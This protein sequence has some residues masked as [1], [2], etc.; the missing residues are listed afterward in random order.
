MIMNQHMFVKWCIWFVSAIMASIMCHHRRSLQI[1][2]AAAAAAATVPA[3]AIYNPAALRMTAAA[4]KNGGNQHQDKKKW[5]QM[6]LLH[7]IIDAQT[8][9]Y[10]H[11]NNS[12][13]LVAQ[14]TTIYIVLTG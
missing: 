12:I 5:G 1:A 4:L 2:A 3:A 8:P 6:H 14:M 7:I 11:L 10:M 9:T 13:P